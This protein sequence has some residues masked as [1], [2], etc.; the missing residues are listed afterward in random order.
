MSSL[1]AAFRY[2]SKG[3][4]YSSEFRFF[5]SWICMSCFMLHELHCRSHPWALFS[6]RLLFDILKYGPGRELCV[7]SYVSERICVSVRMSRQAMTAETHFCS[8]ETKLS[9]FSPQLKIQHSVVRKEH[10]HLSVWVRS[11]FQC[12]SVPNSHI[13]A[14]AV[15]P[16][17]GGL[18][19]NKPS[20]NVLLNI[21]LTSHKRTFYY[22][23]FPWNIS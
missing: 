9:A 3:E 2:H 5:D 14:L 16:G 12:S 8:A 19:C 6:F 23:L 15:L 4:T 18:I 7:R 17:G 21:S 22:L 13:R 10:S 1:C 20:V 11:Q